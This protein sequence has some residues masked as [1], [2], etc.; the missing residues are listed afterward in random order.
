VFWD[1]GFTFDNRV[2]GK[3]FKGLRGE[4]RD[5]VDDEPKLEILQRHLAPVHNDPL[6]LLVHVPWFRV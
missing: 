5:K 4:R 1:L 6:I 3:A 2:F